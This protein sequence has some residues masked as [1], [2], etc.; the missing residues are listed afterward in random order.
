MKGKQ[1]Y[2]FYILHTHI[3]VITWVAQQ[4]V[5]TFAGVET[6]FLIGLRKVENLIIDQA[7]NSGRVTS[8][9]SFCDYD[10]RYTYSLV[11]RKFMVNSEYL[12]R[13]SNMGIFE[14]GS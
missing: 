9:R 8:L 1:T 10:F 4:K 5:S 14:N 12:L 6:T 2:L 13:S 11:M 7:K 3:S